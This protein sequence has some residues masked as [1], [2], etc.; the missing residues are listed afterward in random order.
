MPLLLKLE[1][2]ELALERAIDSGDPSLMYRV[3]AQ[4]KEALPKAEFVLRI[5]SYR[6]AYRV[7]L[8]YLRYASNVKALRNYLFQEDAHREEALWRLRDSHASGDLD[9]R[10]SALQSAVEQFARVRQCAELRALS[11]EQR[12]LL[13]YQVQLEK[14]FN[15]SYLDRSLCDTFRALLEERQFRLADE[16]R[17]EFSIGDRLAAYIRVDALAK[18]ADYDELDKFARRRPPF[19]SGFV[20]VV[21]AC[22]RYDNRIES[23]L[24]KD[25]LEVRTYLLRGCVDPL[26]PSPP[27][28]GRYMILLR[29]FC[30]R[31]AHLG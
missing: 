21:E 18:I 17:K 30:K 19:Q 22:L 20:P 11:D 27:S 3:V 8:R 15:R 10:S 31:L 28:C 13:K 23:A 26:S 14:K 12:R 2:R 24:K 9:E 6:D 25:K 1:R 16:L 7:Y 5:R 29:A 4:L